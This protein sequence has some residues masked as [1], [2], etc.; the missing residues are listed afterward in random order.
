MQ[1]VKPS[2]VG[3]EY[4]GSLYFRS[5]DARIFNVDT[6]GRGDLLMHEIVLEKESA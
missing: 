5:H 3:M 2:E 1:Q 4:D 6:N